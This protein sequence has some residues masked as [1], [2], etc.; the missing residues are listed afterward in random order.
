MDRRRTV[1]RL[2]ETHFTAFR[3]SQRRTISDLSTGLLARGTLSLAEIARGMDDATTVRHRIKRAWRFMRNDRVAPALATEVLSRWTLSNPTVEVVVAID[4]TDLGEYQLLAA[5]VAVASRAVP[6]AWLVMKKRRFTR[7][8]KSRND[9]EEQLIERLRGAL[10]GRRWVLVGDRGFARAA[11]FRKLNAWGIDYVIRASGN[12]WIDS[13]GFSGILDNVPRRAGRLSYRK[14]RYHKRE[15]VPTRLALTHCEPAPEPWYLVTNVATAAHA[16]RLYR[17]R[18][19]IE[20]GF[21]DAKST[22]GLK[23]AW[24]SGAERMERLMIL[25]AVVMLLA[26]LVGLRYRRRFG[27][28]D[29]QLSTKRRGGSLSVFRTGLELIRQHGPPPDLDRIPLLSPEDDT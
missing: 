19:W 3:K 29:P 5:K 6:L 18:M 21:R 9:A 15:R 22:L 28:R 1:H 11:L 26:I 24:L 4:W 20:E 14:V 25:V 13:C 7:R 27:Q 10:A 12:V 8:R 2:I 16:V 23:R 17:K